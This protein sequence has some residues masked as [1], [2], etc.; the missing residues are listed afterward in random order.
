MQKQ[1]WNAEQYQKNASFVSQL[2]NSVLELLAPQP[3]EK[4]LD[5]GCG[6]GELTLQIQNYYCDVLGIDASKSMIESAKQK[7]LT[8]QVLAAENLN[9][10]AEFD[11]VFT[12]AVLHWVTDIDEV[13]NRVYTALKPEGRFIGEFG[14]QGNIQS[15]VNAISATFQEF[16]TFGEFNNPWYFPSVA[17]F[18]TVLKQADFT[19]EYLE[20]IPRPTPL[21]SGIDFWL[22]IFANG[23]T[24]CLN[25]EQKSQFI[26]EVTKKLKPLIYSETEG[27]IADYVRIRFQARK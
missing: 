20:L 8:A 26:A 15:L 9:Y 23:I 1:N 12:N 17:E 14:G 2:G 6:N 24:D 27:W 7:G 21:K 18:Y 5:L 11:A 25:P 19:V 16:K 10:P 22:E 4:I 13:V 3:G